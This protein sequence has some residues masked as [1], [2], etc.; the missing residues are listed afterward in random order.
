MTEDDAL[1]ELAILTAAAL[2]PVLTTAELAQALASGKLA[3]SAGRPPT[4]AAY[5]TTW[6]LDRA[7]VMGWRIKAGKAASDFNFA[8]IGSQY[9]RSQVIA[10]CLSMARDYARRITATVRLRGSTAVSAT[11]VTGA[12]NYVF[13][14]QLP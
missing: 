4:D 7:A 2:Y 12:T 6:D 1:A 8:E 14:D 10:N 3:D 13:P 11:T 9:S 5:E